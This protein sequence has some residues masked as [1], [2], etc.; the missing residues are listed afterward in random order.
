VQDDGLAF[1]NR[2][3]KLLKKLT[4]K[5]LKIK[6]LKELESFVQMVVSYQG[7]AVIQEVDFD[8]NDPLEYEQA[9]M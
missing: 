2:K 9:I 4:D 3:K 7:K 1:R 8:D 5:Q 6:A